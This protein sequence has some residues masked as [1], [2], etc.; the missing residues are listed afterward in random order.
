M[1]EFIPEGK[2]VITGASSGIGA[3]Y[4]DRLAALGHDL[5]LVARNTERLEAL[6]EKLRG[7]TQRNI[8]IVSADLTSKVDLRRVEDILKNDSQ[9]SALV[10]NAGFGGASS[11][12]TSDVD[13]ME[14]MIDLN[15]T[16]PTR[17]TYALVPRLVERK[18]GV[19]INIA[20]IAAVAPETLNGVYGGTKAFVLTF[21]RS[22]HHELSDKGIRVQAVLPGATRTD[23]W[24]I[25]GQPVEN[26]PA[27]MVM[28]AEDMVDAALTGLGM[29]EL[30]T[31]PSLPDIQD[32]Q[33]VDNSLKALRGKLSLSKPANRYLKI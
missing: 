29:N 23:F 14:H 31:I 4:A 25:A 3:V 22:L 17:L 26:L 20:S 12:L 1:S 11:L 18:N 6:A 5:I 16:A 27:S 9:I 24:D 33:A 21:T 10:N 19:I 28:S 15:V 30:I 13:R 8:E 7:R 2:A 32:W